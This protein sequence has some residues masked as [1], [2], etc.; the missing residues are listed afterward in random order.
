MA[1]PQRHHPA[2]DLDDLLGRGD[3]AWSNGDRQGAHDLYR[4]AQQID[5]NDPRV[6]SRLGMTLT[7]VARD[8]YKGVAFCEEALRRGCD[9]ADSLWRL[10]LVYQATFQRER[11]VRAVRRG[12]QIDGNHPGLI[13]LIVALGVRSPPV[14][15]FLKR[16]H[17]LNKYL[18][19]LRHRLRSEKDEG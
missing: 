10:A 2:T 14:L 9:D 11:A 12:L 18:G 3:D 16:S 15:S 4:A 6:L 1:Q 7:I 19:L 13:D 17:P 8:E 5:G